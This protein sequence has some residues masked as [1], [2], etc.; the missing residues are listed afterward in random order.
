MNNPCDSIKDRLGQFSIEDAINKGKIN[1]KTTIVE[2]TAR[3]T[4]IG[5]AFSCTK[6][7]F[8]NYPSST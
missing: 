2:P 8:K 7:S 4:G 5:L 6:I 1:K 3:N